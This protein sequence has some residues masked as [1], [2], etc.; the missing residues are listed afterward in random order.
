MEAKR[1]LK[2]LEM[3]DLM[4]KK[5]NPEWKSMG[6]SWDTAMWME[7]AE[8]LEHY[9]W[10]WWKKQEPDMAQAKMELIDIWHFGLSSLVQHN[11]SDTS[12]EQ[13]AKEIADDHHGEF[14]GKPLV[15]FKTSVEDFVHHTVETGQFSVE[16]FANLANHLG[17]SFNELYTTYVGK[18]V[19]NMFRQDN[20]Y[21]E[22]TYIKDWHGEEDNVHLVRILNNVDK[23]LLN[24]KDEIYLRLNTIYSGVV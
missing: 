22:G 7:A 1:L 18:N 3:Q 20:G 13:L 9:G 16:R 19:L 11:E 24:V 17:L 8:M 12:L 21:K 23:T 5:V 10:K 15:D 6:W 2:M 14:D 4:N